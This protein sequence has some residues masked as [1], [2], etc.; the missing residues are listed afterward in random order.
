MTPWK[1]AECKCARRAQRHRRAR[2]PRR[3]AFRSTLRGRRRQPGTQ[4]RLSLPREPLR[5]AARPWPRLLDGG[6]RS[7]ILPSVPLGRCGA[8]A[9]G[10]SGRSRCRLLRVCEGQGRERRGCWPTDVHGVPCGKGKEQSAVIVAEAAG[11]TPGTS[12]RAGARVRKLTWAAAPRA[13][14]KGRVEAWRATG[15]EVA[16]R[17]AGGPGRSSA[18]LG[19]RRQ[20]RAWGAWADGQAAG[21][22]GQWSSPG[23]LAASLGASSGPLGS[24]TEGPR[25]AGP[26]PCGVRSSVGLGEPSGKRDGR[27]WW[28][29]MRTEHTEGGGQRAP[30]ARGGGP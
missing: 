5:R 26:G 22:G 1:R 30:G 2:E 23:R 17:R 14:R 6:P 12:R 15:R 24:R 25:A 29:V 7:P 19:D 13:A 4:P 16:G 28:F 18:G 8:W 3:A 27:L 20:P 10:E 11:D 21:G 9:V